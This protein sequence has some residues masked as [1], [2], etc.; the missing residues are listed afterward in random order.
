MADPVSMMGPQI[1]MQGTQSS[2]TY[3]IHGYDTG[4]KGQVPHV[5][6][7]QDMCLAGVR[8]RVVIQ[9]SSYQSDGTPSIA[10][11]ICRS[12]RALYHPSFTTSHHGLFGFIT[13]AITG[14][15]IMVVW[16][17]PRE[18]YMLLYVVRSGEKLPSHLLECI[19]VLPCKGDRI[20]IVRIRSVD[21]TLVL[22][23]GDYE[24]GISGRISYSHDCVLQDP[25]GQRRFHLSL[26]C[27]VMHG[28]GLVLHG[29][30]VRSV[31]SSAPFG[32]GAVPSVMHFTPR[33]MLREMP[34]I[35]EDGPPPIIWRGVQRGL[36]GCR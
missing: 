18:L 9:L 11:D 3:C 15:A 24:A 30:T 4:I 22:P 12:G 1:G 33:H 14:E 35:P 17:T 36:P 7:E 16:A 31:M 2:G 6:Q 8:Y 29:V 10:V 21:M 20:T 23:P 19:G 13:R 27:K 26:Q 28:G 32:E 34:M 25:G 5:I